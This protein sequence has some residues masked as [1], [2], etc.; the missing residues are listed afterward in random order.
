MP[1]IV[2]LT[3]NPALDVTTF[4][5]EV[6][7]TRKLRCE[8]P[9]YD[10]G[11]GGINVAKVARVLG[12]SAGAVFPVGGARGRQMSGLLDDDHVDAYVVPIVD[13][14]RECFTAIDRKTGLEYRFVTPGPDL[15]RD[16]QERCLAVLTEAARGA[17][18]LVASGSFPP[19]VSGAFVHRVAEVAHAAGAR[20]VLD[21]SG[22]ALAS[23]E[24]GVFLVKPSLG[25]LCEWVGRDLPGT[26]DRIEASREL[27]ERGVAEIV[28]VSLG[29]DGAIMVTA[30]DAV[31]VPAL[32]VEVRSAVGAGDSM[33]AG[34]VVGLL[35]ERTL[36][37]ALALGVACGTAALLTAG[38][39][40]CRREDIDR[41]DAVARST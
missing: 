4:A 1:D 27:V 10:A 12:A 5:E 38:S 35:Q 40:V 32:E 39:R 16:E 22:E 18:Y 14:T 8:E 37:D 11:G 41:F 21:S 20:F 31:E 15:T 23:I 17:Q 19:G 2:T 28:V 3:M 34:L 24:S 30:D 9:F 36:R 6:V 29:P 26:D 7:P 33:V 25:E 13:D